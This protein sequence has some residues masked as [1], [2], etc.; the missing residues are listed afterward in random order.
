V[1]EFDE[2]C[3]ASLAGQVERG[4]RSLWNA[5]AYV[6]H[7]RARLEQHQRAIKKLSSPAPLPPIHTPDARGEYRSHAEE[8]LAEGEKYADLTRMPGAEEFQ[9]YIDRQDP[10]K[11]RQVSWGSDV[12]RAT[13]NIISTWN[14][15]KGIA[16]DKRADDW[17]TLP[18]EQEFIDALREVARDASKR[19]RSRS[20][21]TVTP[22]TSRG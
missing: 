9:E 13:A 10:V 4:E 19:F 12:G 1:L 3:G 15:L 17:D 18:A 2:E 6:R 16:K 14:S 7:E 5:H 20:T 8:S 22:I 11:V 21:A